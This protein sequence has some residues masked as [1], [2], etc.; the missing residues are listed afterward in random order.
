M[1]SSNRED[2]LSPT[3]KADIHAPSPEH[4]LEGEVSLVG[5]LLSDRYRIER[6]LGHGAMGSVYLAEHTLMH[7]RVAIKVLHAEM[8]RSPEV[9][10]RFER[11][12]VAAGHI[13]HPN[14]ASASDFGKLD[15]GSFFLVLEYIE[16]IGL[17]DALEQYGHLPPKRALHIAAQ[18]CSAL[19]RAHEL[20]IV[21]RDLKPENVMLVDRGGDPDFVKVLDF[22]IARVPIGALSVAN[23]ESSV[24]E[25]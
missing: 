4:D 7:K 1:T 13:E 20:G 22:G 15:D 19:V 23:M 6:H 5:Q 24:E 2:Q 12:A 11:E 14:V 10:A 9:V 8:S 17:R 3:K 16:G 18:I 21:H 25:G